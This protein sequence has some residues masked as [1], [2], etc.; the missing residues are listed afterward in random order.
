MGVIALQNLRDEEMDAFW[1]CQNLIVPE[2]QNTIS[3]ALQKSDSIRLMF[4]RTIMLAAVD[5]NDQS[6]FMAQKIGDIATDRHLTT[7]LAAHH[8]PRA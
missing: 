1:I 8:L 2:T 3:L 7:E 6:G 4:R 5:F